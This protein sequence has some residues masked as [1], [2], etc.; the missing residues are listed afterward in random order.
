MTSCLISAASLIILLSV[1]LQAQIESRA[2]QLDLL[3][4]D[5]VARLWPERQ[6]AFVNLI[7]KYVERGGFED[8]A[9]GANGFEPAVLGGMRSGNGFAYGV[10]YRRSDLWHDRVDFRLTARGTTEQAYMFDFRGALKKLETE[11][12]FVDFYAKFE[13]SPLMDYYGPGPESK[14]S[15][16]TSY[17]LEDTELDLRAGYRPTR[18]LS[19]AARVGGY[20]V[21]TGRGRRSGF[22]STDEI[23]DPQ[24]TPG[25]LEQTK[26]FRWGGTLRFDYRD[27]PSGPRRGGNYYLRFTRYSDR[28]LRKHTFNRLVGFAEQYLPYHND[29]RVIALRLEGATAFV[30]EGSGQ[31]VPFYLQPTLGGNGR[32]RGFARYRFYDQT[33]VLATLEHRW[34]VFTGLDAAVFVETGKVAPRN[35]LLN[36]NELE[37]SGGISLRF[38]INKNFFMR[39]DNAVS[40]EGYRWMLTFGDVFGRENRW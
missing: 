13:N 21:N 1:P 5:K 18:H 19:A 12:A 17:R 37:W 34:Y 26:F 24:V 3:R 10:G 16:R 7:N 38:K 20:F 11:R 9:K 15:N 33:S 28:S 29:T 39:L 31:T 4:R 25:L 36:L 2:Q 22:P 27:N 35:G 14:K 8:S 32:L 30:D 23:F 6:S 40:R